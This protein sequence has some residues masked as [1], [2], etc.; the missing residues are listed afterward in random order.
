MAFE[1]LKHCSPVKKQA[2]V[3]GGEWE[4]PG[5]AKTEVAW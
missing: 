1:F 4:A 3:L 2:T 5:E